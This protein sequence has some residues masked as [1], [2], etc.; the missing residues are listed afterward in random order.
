MGPRGISCPKLAHGVSQEVVAF[1][2]QGRR[3]KSGK[4]GTEAVACHG[5]VVMRV[6][7]RC[8]LQRGDDL[9]GDGVPGAVSGVKEKPPEG[10][11]P[12]SLRAVMYSTR[13]AIGADSRQGHKRVS[14]V[15]GKILKI[16]SAAEGED[17]LMLDIAPEQR[18]LRIRGRLRKVLHDSRTVRR[19]RT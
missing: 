9:R 18:R 7:R 2:S 10:Y 13:T 16:R 3:G 5:Q 11:Q 19:R 15:G 4:S 6:C 17:E 14:E 8:L 1:R 12:R